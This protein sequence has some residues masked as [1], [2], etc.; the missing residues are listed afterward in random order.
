MMTIETAIGGVAALCTTIS[1][2][3]SRHLKNAGKRVRPETCL[4]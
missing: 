3:L 2:F 4:F 1:Y